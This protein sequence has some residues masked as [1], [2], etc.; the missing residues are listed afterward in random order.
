MASVPN[1]SL[2]P[3]EYLA[4]ERKAE[5]KSEYLDLTRNILNP[6]F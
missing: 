4:L 2:S 3:E 5:F 6:D 1:Y